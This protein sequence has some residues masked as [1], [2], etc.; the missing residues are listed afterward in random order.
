MARLKNTK[1]LQ[2]VYRIVNFSTGKSY[3][4]LTVNS[5]R[6]ESEHFTSLKFNRHI[7]PH[8]QY[9][10]NK[11][12]RS[13]FY[14]EI[15]EKD[16]PLSE[17]AA[18]EVYWI[19]AI[20][21]DHKLYNINEGGGGGNISRA[22]PVTWNGIEYK[23]Q[24]EAVVATGICKPTL[25][26]YVELGYTCDS[27]IPP[28]ARHRSVTWNGI[29]YPNIKAAAKANNM[30]WDRLGDRVALGFTCDNDVEFPGYRK[31]IWNGVEYPTISAAAKAN[32]LNYGL[33][34]SRISRYGHTRDEDVIPRAKPITW[35]GIEYPSIRQ[36]SIANGIVDLG[37]YIKRGYTCDDD[38][39]EYQNK[40]RA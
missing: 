5:K 8:L 3:I 38:I 10:Y 40:K 39:H 28:H 26:K 2:C 9:A 31:V 27:D 15:L 13:A 1:A 17:I 34:K 21:K 25:K 37:R 24:T 36:A 32:N 4:G 16:I 19:N 23:T 11:Y 7:N 30:S 35:N 14:F 18:R 6:R 20:G 12:G 33:L 29:T 22:K